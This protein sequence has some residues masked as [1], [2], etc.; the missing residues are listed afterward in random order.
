MII[1]TT[2]VVINEE[3]ILKFDLVRLTGNSR[4]ALLAAALEAQDSGYVLMCKIP[5]PDSDKIEVNV[6]DVVEG[7]EVSDEALE[8]AQQQRNIIMR[9][10][11]DATPLPPDYQINIV[12]GVVTESYTIEEDDNDTDSTKD[13][14]A[15]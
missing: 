8:H 6:F 9:K 15:P 13:Q 4:E 11:E 3:N 7:E 10:E 1:E 12:E 5:T 14:R 2:S